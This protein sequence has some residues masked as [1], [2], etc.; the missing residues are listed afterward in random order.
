MSPA[1]AVALPR[2]SI[3]HPHCDVFFGQRSLFGGRRRNG[4]DAVFV[5]GF[6]VIFVGAFGQGQ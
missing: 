5:S 6:D 4:Q 2:S 1:T 3:R